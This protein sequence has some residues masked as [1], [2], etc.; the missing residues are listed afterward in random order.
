MIV[1]LVVPL[2]GVGQCM[3]DEH[4]VPA[5]SQQHPIVQTWYDN[6]LESMLTRFGH[7]LILT[8]CSA[9]L[10]L[11]L[12]PYPLITSRATLSRTSHYP[13]CIKGFPRWILPSRCA[14]AVPS[15]HVRASFIIHAL[16]NASF[17]RCNLF[18]QRRNRH[19]K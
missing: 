10:L 15:L 4:A 19:E 13:M 1:P 2:T 14:P 6:Q 7:H 3:N 11:A 8:T 9:H 18:S 5:P 12:L 17:M 16:D